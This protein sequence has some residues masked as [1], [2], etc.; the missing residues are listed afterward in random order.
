M[1]KIVG[2]I[3]TGILT[4]LFLFPFQVT[5]LPGNTKMFLA[6]GGLVVLGVELAK[7]QSATIDKNISTLSIIA[8]AVS[9]I[10]LVSV[11]CNNTSDYA[12]A[13]YIMSMWV[14]LGAAYFIV[15]MMQA[16]HGRL[17]V[18][19]ICN[20]LIAVCVM[21]CFASI[22]IDRYPSFR[23]VVDKYVQ[24][25]QEFLKHTVGVRRKYG[26]GANLDVAGSRFS[27]V[28]IM[29]AF[30]IPKAN[31]SK[32]TILALL[33]FLCFLFISVQGNA[34]ARTTTVG[35]LIG[36]VV[37]VIYYLSSFARPSDKRGYFVPL[38]IVVILFLI[39]VVTYLYNTDEQ[40]YEDM[41]FG[42]EGFFSLAE[43]GEW[44]VSSNDRL[45]TMYVWPDNYKTW[46]IGDGYFSNPVDTDSY[47]VGEVTGG[48][49]KGTDAGY[50][51][52]IYYFGLLGLLAFS[53]FMCYA[54]KICMDA[55][56]NYKWMFLL[57][58]AANFIVWFKVSTDLFVVFAPFLT[59]SAV[60]QL[61]E[62]SKQIF[63]A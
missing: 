9:F 14:W 5:G 19:I 21:Q 15:K 46:I 45:K 63:V 31:E 43:Q 38:G 47:F 22:M 61:D 50:L 11:I 51:R 1:L 18:Q 41:R 25:G 53:V 60:K 29:A 13:T 7:G 56:K 37:I 3:I 8:I 59:L 49:Y 40:F 4:S 23:E 32:N 12:Y 42:F 36:A 33:Y 57:M 35:M 30:L 55:F 54:A 48:Y 6:V 2:I 39:S 58:L 20:Y 24:Q 62:K 17:D 27:A 52:F 16:V 10:G 34:I 28:L 44:A 26:I